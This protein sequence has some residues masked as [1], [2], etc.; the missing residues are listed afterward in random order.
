M[1]MVALACPGIKVFAYGGM[2]VDALWIW[3]WWDGDC[4]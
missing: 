3:L 4:L 2:A 1:I